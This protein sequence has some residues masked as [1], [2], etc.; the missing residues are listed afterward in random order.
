[1]Q[2]TDP[3]LTTPA[4]Y[5]PSLL[6]DCTEQHE[7][8]VLIDEIATTRGLSLQMSLRAM[9]YAAAPD[10]NTRGSVAQ[11]FDGMRQHFHRNLDLAF[12][13]KP[14][15]G[16]IPDHVARIRAAAA[17]DPNR[18]RQM[19]SVAKTVDLMNERLQ[20]AQSLSFADARQFLGQVWPTARDQM[21]QVIWDVWADMDTAREDELRE[22]TTAAEKLGKRLG[23]LHD[24]GK[25]VRLVSLNAS[26][27]AARAGDLGKGLMVI[28]NEFKVLAE[29]IQRLAQDAQ[30]DVGTLS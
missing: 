19:M 22:A 12:G 30:N 11:E 28:A 4:N 23:H 25:H 14:I 21:T 3:H 26:V 17:R 13:T 1:M 20:S 29:E 8:R 24:I 6:Q 16:Q 15:E 5:T 18:H 9:T 27:E 7:L 10:E 2:L